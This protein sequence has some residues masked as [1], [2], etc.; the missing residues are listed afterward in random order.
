MPSLLV[1][2]KLIPY[3][4]DGAPDPMLWQPQ[5]LQIDLLQ[6]RVSMT[7]FCLPWPGLASKEVQQPASSL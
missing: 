1:C 4:V 2:N 6:R 7:E 5:P 3:A